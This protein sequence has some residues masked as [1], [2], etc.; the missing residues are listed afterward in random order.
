M[1]PYSA[2]DADGKIIH[3]G[4]VQPQHFDPATMVA[5]EF[6]PQEFYVA[7]GQVVPIPS[8]PAGD[9]DWDPVLKVWSPNVTRA[10]TGALELRDALLRDTDWR[11]LPDAPGAPGEEALWLQYRKDLR[12]IEGQPG[13]PDNIVW[14]VAPSGGK[15]HGALV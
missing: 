6:D 11:V 13:F 4:W 14:P 12:E 9:H 10:Q 3:T 5:G 8:K 15:R 1:T 2:F 7:A